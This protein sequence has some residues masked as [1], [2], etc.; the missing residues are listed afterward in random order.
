MKNLKKGFTLV[1]L[2]VVIAIIGVLAAVLI[3][4]MLT[5]IQ[6]SRLKT[7]NANAK[8]AY[9]AAAEY[10]AEATIEGKGLVAALEDFT[11]GNSI[12][13]LDCRVRPSAEADLRIYEALSSNGK[14]AGTVWILGAGAG[15]GVPDVIVNGR[16]TF[17]VQ[18]AQNDVNSELW[19]QYPN[20]ISWY[21]YKNHIKGSS[22]HAGWYREVW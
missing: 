6:K 9:N 19:G 10:V 3:P 14:E 5:Y 15:T 8:T 12:P 11:Q 20:P 7:A 22:Y 13:G 2:V 16:A 18:W 4:S 1:E 17:A 21:D